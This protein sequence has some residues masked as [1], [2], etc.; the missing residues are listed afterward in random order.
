MALFGRAP[1]GIEKIED[2]SLLSDQ[3]TG[4][5]WLDEIRPRMLRIHAELQAASDKIKE[6]RVLEANARRASEVAQRHGLIRASTD[7][8]P[9]YVRILYMAQSRRRGTL[10]STAMAHLGSTSTKYSQCALM[11]YCLRFRRTGRY[12]VSHRGSSSGGVNQRPLKM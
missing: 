12:R 2:P 11:Q 5:E 3:N 8:Q 7:D 9:S 10:A 1:T 6:A 4:T